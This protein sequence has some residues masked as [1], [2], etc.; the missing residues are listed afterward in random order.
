MSRK[1]SS[2]IGLVAAL[3]AIAGLQ[4]KSPEEM[5]FE[6]KEFKDDPKTAEQFTKLMEALNK[7][8]PTD[9]DSFVVS[10]VS[11]RPPG[12]E[13][14]RCLGCG[15]FHDTAGMGIIGGVAGG[16]TDLMA[17]I[18]FIC[19]KSGLTAEMMRG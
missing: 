9:V 5:Y 7:I 15:E 10:V 11:R 13:P 14:E 12:Q 6:T 19:D 2:L 18:S 4:S 1:N 3:G 8:S 16:T 17:Q